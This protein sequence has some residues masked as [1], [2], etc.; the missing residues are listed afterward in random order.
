MPR[1]FSDDLLRDLRNRIDMG[2]LFEHLKWPHKQRNG[3]LAFLC[4]CCQ[5]FHSAVNPRTNL[6]RC[7]LCETNFNPID[8]TMRV[9]DCDFVEAVHF[10]RPLL[11]AA[12]H[13]P[14][15]S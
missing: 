1:Y 7:F 5:E 14:T 3:Q 2:R 11:P 13:E 6:G 10:L 15:T 9:R 12:N 8:M 4:P